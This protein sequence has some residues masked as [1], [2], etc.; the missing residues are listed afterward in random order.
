LLSS[1]EVM[2]D[3]NRCVENTATCFSHE[4]GG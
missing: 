3:Q 1:D 4:G 2:I